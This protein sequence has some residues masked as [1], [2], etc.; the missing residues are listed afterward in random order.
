MKYLKLYKEQSHFYNESIRDYLKPKS[1]DK[2]I[3]IKN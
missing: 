1:D 2:I 3:N